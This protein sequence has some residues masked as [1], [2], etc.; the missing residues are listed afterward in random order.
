MHDDELMS[1][2]PSQYKGEFCDSDAE[3]RW[4][5]LFDYLDMPCVREPAHYILGVE[6]G[7]VPDFFMPDH[8]VFVEV[9]SGNVTPEAIDK[10]AAL[11]HYTGKAAMLLNGRPIGGT[12]TLYGP[13]YYHASLLGQ[14]TTNHKK[15]WKSGELCPEIFMYTDPDRHRKVWDAVAYTR[16]GVVTPATVEQRERSKARKKLLKAS[17]VVFVDVDDE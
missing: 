8:D 12:A 10:L 17:S 1:Y 2:I 6:G 9:K 3:G 4:R 16:S 7:Y 14:D 13:G 11:A 15:H 5:A